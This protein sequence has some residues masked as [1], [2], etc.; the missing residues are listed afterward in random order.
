MATAKAEGAIVVAIAAAAFVYSMDK[1]WLQG[2]PILVFAIQFIVLF[3][4]MIWAAFAA[5]RHADS[6]AEMLGEPYGTLILTLS[7]I[8]IEVSVISAVMLAGDSSPTLAR[9][10]MLA[11]LMIVLNAMVGISLLIGG[12]KYRQQNYNLEGARTFLSVLITLVTISLVLPTFTVSTDDPS[13]TPQQAMLFS[14][15]TI[16]LYGAFLTIQTVRHRT[17][18]M[19]PGS[20]GTDMVPEHGKHPE[21]ITTR[22]LA[23]HACLLLVTLVTIVLLAKKFG[24]LVEGAIELFH[25]PPALGG[26][27]IALLVLAPEGLAAF[28]AASSNHLQRAVNIC[29]G[30]ALATISLTVP[31]VVIIALYTGT[32]LVLGLERAELV[33]LTLTAVISIMTFSGPRTNVLQGVVLL[34]IF[35]VYI[36]LIFDP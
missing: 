23:Y 5:V 22:S 30:S 18:F 14:A 32:H 8:C 15:A 24:I 33:M 16:V 19:E 20:L 28:K 34:T 26:V 13:L 1:D 27:V 36:I 29:L 9:D 7:V 35:A 17:F 4:V 21:G 6:L 25:A 31:A 11:V 12:R 10:T 3:A 2:Q